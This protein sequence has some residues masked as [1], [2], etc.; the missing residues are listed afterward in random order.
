[1]NS[2][3][4]F[5]LTPRE[6]YRWLTQGIRKDNNEIPP[7]V[8]IAKMTQIRFW[9]EL[10]TQVLDDEALNM[11]SSTK[12][13]RSRSLSNVMNRTGTAG[14]M[15]PLYEAFAKRF[16]STKFLQLTSA[17]LEMLTR[18]DTDWFLFM[19]ALCAFED[20]CMAHDAAISDDIRSHLLTLRDE[21]SE[22]LLIDYQQQGFY[23]CV[24][25]SWLT[26]Y[27]FLG[28]SMDNRRTKLFRQSNGFASATLY[29]KYS[30]VSFG[31]FTPTVLTSRACE[32]CKQALVQDAY[33]SSP[34]SGVK[35][36]YDLMQKRG[37]VLISGAGGTGKTELVRQVLVCARED[38]RYSRMAFV[39][40]EEN[41]TS[42]LRSA[43]M[44]FQ[45][46][47]TDE[48]LAAAVR[49]LDKRYSGRTLLVIDDARFDQPEEWRRIAGLACDVLVTS[50]QHEQDGFAEYRL[51]P[52]GVRET[53]K[54]LESTC[55]YPLSDAYEEFA[56][57]HKRVN[58]HPLAIILLG[59]ALK[60]R[61]MTL[62]ALN[63]ETEHNGYGH[64][65]LVSRGE[66]ESF[67][68]KLRSVFSTTIVDEKSRKL[69]Q[70]FSMLDGENRPA[71]AL[72]SLLADAEPDA[73][74]LAEL[75]YRN[76]LNGWLELNEHGYAMLSPIMQAMRTECGTLADY[77][78]LRQHLTEL[79]ASSGDGL[80]SLGDDAAAGVHMA[81]FLAER[82]GSVPENMLFGAMAYALY[83][84]DENLLR[85]LIPLCRAGSDKE[86]RFVAD[87]ID[88]AFFRGKRGNET[89]S[90]PLDDML[91]AAKTVDFS[92]PLAAL[93]VIAVF[94]KD[95]TEI[96]PEFPAL[97][98]RILQC[99][100]DGICKGFLLMM[101]ATL[102][103]FI[104]G[105]FDAANE[106]LSQALAIDP[107]QKALH[108]QLLLHTAI[109]SVNANADTACYEAAVDKV[110]K[111]V[112]RSD[113]IGR[114]H[115]AKL[116]IYFFSLLADFCDRR[117]L[118]G[119]TREYAQRCI[120]A[121]EKIDDKNAKNDV[122]TLLSI[123]QAYVRIEQLNRALEMNHHAIRLLGKE[124][125]RSPLFCDAWEQRGMI[126]YQLKMYGQSLGVLKKAQ[127]LMY[128]T[129]Q[130]DP[131]RMVYLH[132]GIARTLDAM[133]KKEQAG[134]TIAAVRS[135]YE[136][137]RQ[138][139]FVL[140]EDFR[141]MTVYLWEE[142]A[143]ARSINEKS[144]TESVRAE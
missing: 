109:A 38:E 110:E 133:K 119:K 105:D 57:L 32:A 10:L 100:P 61:N 24:Q 55:G 143:A 50:R 102:S 92:K 68:D 73:G 29:T 7:I 139:G 97:L 76:Y 8:K 28:E 63:R 33:V 115:D 117:Q 101:Y 83:I 93:G 23:C 14:V 52:L 4:C 94:L 123:S 108:Y 126:Y 17:W 43:F 16:D 51:Q 71:E 26:L 131:I 90:S 77:P 99:C 88:S 5:L 142:D 74:K 116:L 1:M 65:R 35:A 87:C 41:L 21:G 135:V 136:D 96:N 82:D 48:V 120:E 40:Y 62:A 140:P 15:S 25:L 18:Y 44:E 36:L 12:A 80:F 45:G 95:E 11:L 86:M 37:K 69:L 112:A 114:T 27:A 85:H 39:Q 70:L 31:S 22:A 64:L 122:L 89:A 141:S 98:A 6:I 34:E 127:A 59:K 130:P 134:Q 60:T 111:L 125:P 20:A 19:D 56:L 118:A 79:F 54:L 124:K 113:L 104:N 107:K 58:G 2:A 78:M 103:L 13:K 46:L 9:C 66:S 144:G 42:S 137:L 138:R 3:D 132:F 84:S 81:V 75:L 47:N 30:K 72:Q 129:Q 67:I 106:M 49:L 53:R 128:E 91:R 121:F